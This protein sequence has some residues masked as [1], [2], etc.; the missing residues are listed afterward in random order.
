MQI[1]LIFVKTLKI[2]RPTSM[3]DA[4]RLAMIWI[5]DS[6]YILMDGLVVVNEHEVTVVTV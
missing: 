3:T 6:P 2:I 5:F 4:D 1:Y